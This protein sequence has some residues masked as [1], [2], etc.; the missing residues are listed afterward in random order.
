M[1]TFILTVMLVAGS[2]DPQVAGS[3][4]EEAQAAREEK[5][6]NL[7]KPERSFLEKGLYEFKERRVMERFKEGRYGFHP[8][9]GGMRSGSGFSAGTSY[10]NGPIRASAEA[11]VRGYKKYE[12]EFTAPRVF[13]DRFFADFRATRRDYPQERFFGVGGKSR[14]EDRTSYRLEDTSY[15]GRFGVAAAKHVKVGILAGWAHPRVGPGT[16]RLVPSIERVFDQDSAPGVTRRNLLL[17]Y[18]QDKF[19]R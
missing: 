14:R 19:L 15:V 11:S 16:D 4:V 3:R 17:R 18:S 5:A 1:M 8:L 9:I 2:Q 7:K 10:E 13:S 12:L 6:Q